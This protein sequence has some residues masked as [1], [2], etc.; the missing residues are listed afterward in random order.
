MTAQDII[1][2]AFAG[3]YEDI[4]NDP[5]AKRFSMDVINVLLADAY[6]AEQYYREMHDETLLTEVPLISSVD[7][8]IPY[9]DALVRAAFPYGVEWKYCEQNLE[10]DRAVQYRT[11]YEAARDAHGGKYYR[12][13]K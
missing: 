6:D 2:M 4:E 5:E 3:E 8:P 7:A 12:R 10:A 11:L 9:N 1:R 13:S